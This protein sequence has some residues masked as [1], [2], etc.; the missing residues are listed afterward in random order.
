LEFDQRA[1]KIEICTFSS[2]CLTFL[3]ELSTLYE[4]ASDKAPR[5]PYKIGENEPPGCVYLD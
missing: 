5:G 2:F 3:N 4:H 1:E